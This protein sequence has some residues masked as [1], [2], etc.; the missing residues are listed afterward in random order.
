MS[1]PWPFAVLAPRANWALLS[2]L[3]HAVLAAWSASQKFNAIDITGAD[4]AREF[5]L[6]DSETKPRTFAEFRGEVVLLFFGFTPCP[7]V[8]PT[9][10]SHAAEVKKQ[11]GNVHDNLQV[12]FVTVDPERDSAIVLKTCTIALDPAFWAGHRCRRYRGTI[13]IPPVFEGLEK[14]HLTPEIKAP[15]F[16]CAT[17]I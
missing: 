7:D 14:M 5:S 2:F 6:Q 11:L 10:L 15:T 9:A 12:I 8:C 3:S 1:L 17:S 16:S 4:Y 13:P